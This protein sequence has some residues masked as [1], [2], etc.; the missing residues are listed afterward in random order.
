MAFHTR[1][2]YNSGPSAK[3]RAKWLHGCLNCSYIGHTGRLGIVYLPT[4]QINTEFVLADSCGDASS[5]G[6]ADS[7]HAGSNSLLNTLLT[8]NCLHCSVLWFMEW[9]TFPISLNLLIPAILQVNLKDD[10]V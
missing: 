1:V 2:D 5:I 10:I 6:R 3:I 4:Q 7:G 9:L 8:Y